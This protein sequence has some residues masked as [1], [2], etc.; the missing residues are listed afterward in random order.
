MNKENSSQIYQKEDIKADG[1]IPQWALD[2]Y[3]QWSKIV[4]DNN[5]PCHFGVHAEKAGYLRYSFL[6]A[7][8]LT[9]LP[10]A[11][12]NFL[13]VSRAHPAIR[14]ALVL[15]VK[16]DEAWQT[17]DEY[18]DYFWDILSYLHE[19]DPSPWPTEV[20]LNPDEP[21][22]EFSFDGEPIFVSGNAPIY[23]KHTTRNL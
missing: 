19:H 14:H 1:T 21:L 8:C 16:P 5:F 18:H 7:Y 9:P 23:E 2:A 17:F 6:N 3:R 20:P 4:S 15:F 10:D 12:L 13:S 22:W 11:L